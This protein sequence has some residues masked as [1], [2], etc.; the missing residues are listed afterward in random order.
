MDMLRPLLLT[1]PE[2]G[3]TAWMAHFDPMALPVLADTAMAFEEWRANEDAVDA[4]LLSETI[5]RDPLMTLKLLATLPMP[6]GAAAGTMR[7]V[8]PRP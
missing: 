2:S 3:L 7:A 6:P 5:V 8:M 4:H 1:R